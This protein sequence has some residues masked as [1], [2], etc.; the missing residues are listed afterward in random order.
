TRRLRRLG[1]EP[2]A[3][4][5][6]LVTALPMRPSLSRRFALTRRMKAFLA[7]HF[8]RFL[9]SRKCSTGILLG[10]HCHLGS[11]ITKVDIFRDAAVIMINY[12]DQIRDQGFEVN[13]LNIGGGLGIDYYHSDAIL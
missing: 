8:V 12:I 9:S 13:Y 1:K 6:R 3:S 11:T 10:V 4:F 7:L 5:T 2:T